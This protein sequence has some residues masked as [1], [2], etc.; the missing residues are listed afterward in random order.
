MSICEFPSGDTEPLL[1]T[2]AELAALLNLSKRT[3]W[4]LRSA[5][6]LP[7]PVKLGNSVRWIR[8]EIKNWIE[9][10]RPSPQARDNGRLRR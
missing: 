3:L 8:D 4:R 10:G 5:G 6:D 7:K 1:I 9:A 2:A